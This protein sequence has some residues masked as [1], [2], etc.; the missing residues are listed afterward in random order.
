VAEVSADDIEAITEWLTA[1]GFVLR[2]DEENP[3]A[4]GNRLREWDRGDVRYR[5][6]RDRGQWFVDTSRSRWEDWFDIDL[7]SY[8]CDFREDT[9]LGRAKAAGNADLDH[10]L[11]AL[12]SARRQQVEDHL[13]IVLPP[14]HP[15]SNDL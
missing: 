2:V 15:Y 4:F 3:S 9:A 7:V 11:P 13:G 1:R 12:R 5:M 14:R 10:L 8:V 6:V